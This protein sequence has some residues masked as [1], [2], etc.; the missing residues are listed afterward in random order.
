MNSDAERYRWFRLWQITAQD[1]MRELKAH[2]EKF[3]DQHVDEMM[4]RFPYW[5]LL[6]RRN[7]DKRIT[8]EE[9][10]DSFRAW[11]YNPPQKL[12]VLQWMR[13]CLSL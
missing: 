11:A 6:K 12:S 5:L 10:N 4:L 13:G 8:I 7:Q 9:R 3:F 1:P 2:E